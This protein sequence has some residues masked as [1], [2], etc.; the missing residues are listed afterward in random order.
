MNPFLEKAPLM[1][2]MGYFTLVVGLKQPLDVYVTNNWKFFII[3]EYQ[4]K[5]KKVKYIKY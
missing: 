3:F 5:Y 1:E 4:F 2:Q